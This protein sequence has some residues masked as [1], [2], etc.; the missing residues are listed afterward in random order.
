MK[1]ILTIAGTGRCG[2]TKLQTILKQVPETFV[3]MDETDESLFNV[4]IPSITNPELADAA[5]KR[6]LFDI[7]NNPLYTPYSTFAVDGHVT[8]NN[9]LHHFI[10]NKVIPH[11]F[12]LR[13]RPR[14]VAKSLFRLGWIPAKSP[15]ILMHF[16]GPNEGDVM[17]FNDWQTAHSYQLCFWYCCEI[18]RRLKNVKNLLIGNDVPFFEMTLEEMLDV[19]I[20]NKAL[21]LF[22]LPTIQNI[23]KEKENATARY[24]NSYQ[25]LVLDEDPP[26][27]FLHNLELDVL[28]R[29]P[30]EEKEYI[31][32]SW[33]KIW[34]DL[35]Y[36]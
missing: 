32:D 14:E 11:T 25:L 16:N 24:K 6:K 34:P 18:E 31:L 23:T 5:V 3:E 7:E 1:K 26:E 15:L 20:F 12:I 19:N 13:R 33:Y 27:E 10:N 2:T 22:N 28:N 36:R 17:S 9:F 21:E 8:G 29:I 35:P 4:R 30:R